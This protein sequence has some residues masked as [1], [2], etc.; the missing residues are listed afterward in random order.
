MS[1]ESAISEQ[2]QNKII[3]EI[4]ELQRSY[5]YENKNKETERGRKLREIIDR[6]TPLA[7]V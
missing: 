3:A 2:Q 5:Y 7:S 6:A 4:L 1:I